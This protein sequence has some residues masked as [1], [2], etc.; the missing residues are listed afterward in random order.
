MKLQTTKTQKILNKIPAKLCL[1][2]SGVLCLAGGI[3]M[4]YRPTHAILSEYSL[5][6]SN[7]TLDGEHDGSAT[8]ALKTSVAR[9]YTAIQGTY[10]LH[11]AVGSEEDPT[12][13][14]LSGMTRGGSIA[15]AYGETNGVVAWTPDPG[16]DGMSVV[17]NGEVLTA[18]YT[19]DK[20]TP[21]GTYT[22]SFSD[23]LFTYDVSGSDVEEED[24]IALDATV[25]V[26]RDTTGGDDDTDNNTDGEEDE[27]AA[28]TIDEEEDED[29]ESGLAVPNTGKMTGDGNGASIVAIS[30][31]AIIAVI[32]LFALAAQIK[33]HKH[34][35]FDQNR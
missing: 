11:E 19:V 6:G 18:T 14:S 30:T 31:A 21:A 27:D 35:D 1:A 33:N 22:I 34:I 16:A 12:Y 23:G 10:S 9:T 17:A 4:T 15:T 8:V 29:E 7:V 24:T 3:G 13:L 28:G 5:A 26:T 25:T 32:A 20:D 2:A